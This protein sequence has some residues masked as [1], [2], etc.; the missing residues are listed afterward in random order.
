MNAAVVKRLIR[1][2]FVVGAC[3]ISYLLWLVAH[4]P[5]TDDAQTA[6]RIGKAMAQHYGHFPAR[7]L[8]ER[9]G[10]GQIYYSHPGAFERPRVDLYEITSPQDMAQIEQ[11][12][13]QALTDVPANSVTLRFFEK[14]NLT[15]F[16]S[17]GRGHGP[18]HLIKTAV[19]QHG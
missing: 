2:V 18:E 14:E 15:L 17:G 5:S 11:A 10:H 7:S 6:D 8:V 1:V 16:A 13:R 9:Q 4:I 3:L 12:V 19:I